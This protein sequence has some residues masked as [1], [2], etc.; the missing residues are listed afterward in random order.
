M[1]DKVI[2]GVTLSL[3]LLVTLVIYGLV[4][5]NRGPAATLIDRERAVDEG[6]HTFAQ[7]CI[8]CHGPQGEGCIGPAL[9][10]TTWR[11]EING[12]KNPDFDDA[13]HDFMKKV[14]V[15]GR[16]SNQPGIQMP[17][18]GL[19]EGG[20]LN[21][22]KIENVIAF[23]QYGNWGTTLENAASATGL[24][25]PLPSYPGFQD[26][27]KIA[28]VKQLM[29]TKGCLN[30]HNLGKGGGKVAADLTEVGSRRT[31]DWLRKWIHDPKSVPA[32]ERGPNLWLLAPTPSLDTPGPNSGPTA[33]PQS[34][35]MNTT[36]MP[37]IP[38]T[39]AE[40]SLLVDYLS[41]AKIAKK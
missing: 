2:L 11:P 32:T 25:E 6:N 3:V 30:C 14:I 15:R 24:E 36:Y 28:Q 18:W 40:L 31:A 1:R 13:S 35:P 26:T 10:R 12:A 33:T 4:D 7:Y 22:E 34:L 16:Q 5:T 8:Q 17:P 38:M 27:A 9:N 37:T 23:I 41:H 19:S 29:L 21:D 39:D 20:P